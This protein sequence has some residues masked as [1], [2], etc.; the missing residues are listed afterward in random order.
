MKRM[1][2]R[3]TAMLMSVIMLVSFLLP[4]Y[5]TAMA[6][7]STLDS[8]NGTPEGLVIT[9]PDGTTE[10]VDE[11]WEDEFPYGIFAL[12]KS[13]MMLAEGGDTRVLTVYRLGG[14][15]GKASAIIQYV[16]A[17]TENA[18]GTYSYNSA[19]SADDIVIAVEDALPIT[20]Y[21]AWGKPA[22]PEASGTKLLAKDG[23][24]GEG[25]E[26]I[27]LYTEIE[28]E[29]YVWYVL[30]DGE[31]IEIDYA[32]GKELP[33][34]E[35]DLES[36]D[37][38]CVYTVDGVSYSTDSYNGVAYEK[39]EAEVLPEMPQ[40]INL[41]PEKTYT[42]L[43]L[44]EGEDMYSGWL[45]E[46][47]FADGEYQ[48]DILIT[49][50]DD[51]AAELQ[52]FATF[53]IVDNVGG[54]VHESINTTIISI[55][56][57]DE[58]IA[59][60]AVIG[61][62]IDEASFDK[63]N[64]TAVLTVERTDNGTKAVS[65]DWSV[66]D[67]SAKS[68][69]DFVSSSGTLYF[70]GE[71]NT[72]T[73]TLEL[74]N[75]KVESYEDKEFT[76]KLSNILGD[77]GAAFSSDTCT[78]KLFNSDSSDVLNLPSTVY[79]IDAEDVSGSVKEDSSANMHSGVIGGTQ[80]EGNGLNPL[81]AGNNYATIDW[82]G[83]NG[84]ELSPLLYSGYGKITFP[85]GSWQRTVSHT[86]T[87]SGK[88][89]HTTTKSIPKLGSMY[90]KLVSNTTGIAALASAWKLTWRGM[91]YTYSYFQYKLGDK[92]VRKN[93]EHRAWKSGTTYNV[94][95]S[96]NIYL[97]ESWGYSNNDGSITVG[98]ARHDAHDCEN[99]ISATAKVELRRR[100]YDNNFYLDIYT[101]NDDDMK[102]VAKYSKDNYENIEP[103]IAYV[104][105]AGGASGG[106]MYVGSSFKLTLGNT[107]L[108]C[109]AAYIVNGNNV[110]ARG[111]VSGNTATFSN[112]NT[113]PSGD[114]Y[115][116]VI[117]DRKQNINI[118]VDTSSE[119]DANGNLVANA[120]ETAAALFKSRVADGKVTVG[121][122]VRANSDRYL[123][124]NT[125]AE[126]S[127]DIK[128][129]SLS[130]GILKLVS[131]NNVANIQYINFNLP[132]EDVVMFAGKA[133][134]GNDK[135]YLETKHLTPND[136]QFLYYHE[137]FLTAQRPMRVTLDSTAVYFD[138]NGN[139]QI[140]GYF[141]VESGV[142]VLTEV[143]G[144]KDEFVAYLD[145][146]DYEETTFAPKT[147]GSGK[148]Y[149][150]FMRPYYTANPVCLVIP[151]GHSE[152][153]RM[154]VMPNFITDVTNSSSYEA[155]TDE[156]KQYRTIISG[157]TK[158]ESDGALHYS[159]DNHY[160]YT[161]AASAY[162]YIDIPLGGDTNP[163]YAVESKDLKASAPQNGR[164]T[165]D[166]VSYMAKD[167]LA[168]Y[169]SA[170]GNENLGNAVYKWEPKYYGN[171]LYDFDAPSPINIAHSIAGDNI[172]ITS[173]LETVYQKVDGTWTTT[174]PTGNGAGYAKNSLG[175]YVVSVRAK[176]DGIKALNE[177]LGSFAD[178][179]T[180][181]LIVNEQSRT[182]GE[183]LDGL[184]TL[185]DSDD[186]TAETVTRG[187]VGL[188]PNSDY[189]KQNSS[190]RAGGSQSN[191]GQSEY[192][193]F[194]MDA[195]PNLFSFSSSALGMLSVETDG[196]EISLGIGIPVYSKDTGGQTGSAVNTFTDIKETG[197][198]IGQF[199]RD[200]K[201][202][203]GNAWSNLTSDDF[204]NKGNM[205]KSF[206]F[207]LSVAIGIKLKYN[208]LD[209][210][211]K[212]AEAAISF[213]AGVEFR[214]QYRFT[215][216]P[217]LYV[218]AQFGFEVTVQTG[219]GQD[220]E[221]V[222]GKVILN[223]KTI[224]LNSGADGE[225]K[226]YYAFITD[227]K[228][229]NV[230]FDGKMLMEFYDVDDK[231]NNGI[232]DEGIDEVIAPAEGYN[233]GFISSDGKSNTEVVIKRQDGFELDKDVLVILTAINDGEKSKK[234]NINRIALIKDVKQD[235]YW[236]GVSI[237]LSGSIELGAGIGIDLAKAE[238][239]VKANI[240]F[241]FTLGAYDNEANKQMPATIDEFG[242]S[243]GI[244]FRIVLLF[245]D[246]EQD[247]INYFLKYSDDKWTHGWSALG[248]KYGG[249]S[250]LSVGEDEK[251]NVYI[252]TPSQVR[253][254][255]YGNNVNGTEGDLTEQ[256]YTSN[257][258]DF[259]VSGYGASVNAF[260]LIGDVETGYDYKIV[261]VGE[262]NY[263]VYTGTNKN[264]GAA[265]DNTELWLS[266]LEE[267]D[268]VY[269]FVNPIAGKGTAP[270]K[271]ITV[272]GD[273]TGDLDFYAWADEDGKSINVVWVSYDEKTTVSAK[274][275]GNAYG[276]M[277]AE[278]YKTIAKP[279]SPAGN[280]PIRSDYHISS[281][282]YSALSELLKDGYTLDAVSG[283]YYA[284][285]Y[286][287]LSAA[288]QAFTNADAA[289]KSAVEAVESY[290]KWYSYFRGNDPEMQLVDASQN[291]VVKFASFDTADTASEGFTSAVE[292]S[293]DAITTY[294]FLPRSAGEATVYA[295]S[296][297]YSDE[298]LEERLEEYEDY[299]DNI[300]KFDSSEVDDSYENSSKNYLEASKQYRLNYQRGMLSVYGGNSRLTV[301]IPGKT[302]TNNVMYVSRHQ[303]D[304]NG[305]AAEQT[306]EILT[307]I[308]IAE[309]DGTYYLAY[310]TSQD[311][312]EA[313]LSDSSSISRFY[314]RTFKVN[315][316][317]AVE[318]GTPYLIR[319]V[320]N[321]EENNA[322]DGAYIGGS[323]VGYKDAYIANVSFL[324]GKIGDKLTGEEEIFSP[325]GVVED[326][327]F[328][329]FEM[330]G[331]TY[332][333]QEDS[334]KSIVGSANK[335]VISPFFTI[336]QTHGDAVAEDTNESHS[337]GKSE[338]VVGAD[339]DGNVAAV[340]TSSVAGTSNNAI[341]ISY[342][343]AENGAWSSGVMLAMNYMDVYER[344]LA[345]GWD[346]L[347][348]EAAYLN[349]ELGGGMTSLVFTNIQMALGRA[350]TPASLNTLS[351]NGE[352][353]VSN[354]VSAYGYGEA[355]TSLGI[356]LPDNEEEM[357]TFAEEFDAAK[358][359]EISEKLELMGI[360]TGLRT[361]DSPE[362]L[363]LTQGA[364]TELY[365]YTGANGSKIIAAKNKK[366]EDTA[367]HSNL[368][369]Y[370]I[371]YGK[372][373]QQVGNASIRFGYNE[374]SVGSKLYAK[375]SFK[376]V[377]D[378]AIRGSVD[379]PITVSLHV[380]DADGAG[381]TLTS[382]QITQSIGAGQTVELSTDKALCA[383]LT[384][385]LGNND[386]FY[387]T[388][389]EHDYAD[390]PYVY[391]SVT[392]ENCFYTFNVENKTELAVEGLEAKI[393]G[394]T[395]EGKSIVETSFDVTNRGS[396]LAEEVY[397]QL[398]Y[399]SRYNEDGSAVYSPLD[400]TDSDIY[401]SHQKLITDD[402]SLLG[403]NDL[404]NGI[405]YLGSDEKFYTE[406]YYITKE[407]YNAILS[408][409][410][411]T[412]SVPGWEKGTYNGNSYWFD[413]LYFNSAYAAYTA[414]QEA[415]SGW[416]KG[417]E[418]YYYNNSYKNFDA[419]KNAA[420]A[421][422]MAEYILNSEQYSA[423]LDSEKES[424]KKATDNQSY[425]IPIGYE[426]YA[427]AYAAYESACE[428]TTQDIM[429]DY[430]R[431]VEGEI[432]VAPDKF[433]GKLT[434]SLDIKVE[435]F[436]KTSGLS[437]V[438]A[439]LHIS[440]HADEYHSI[441]N[442]DTRSLE[443]T[444]FISGAPKIVIARGS[445]YTL[446]VEIR[447]T[448]GKLP[449]ISVVEV[450]DGADEISTLYYTADKD[451]DNVA[452]TATGAV[453][454][455]GRTL[456]EGVI[457]IIDSATNTT[458]P[459]AYVVAE[460]GDGVNIYNDDAQFK[461]YNSDNSPYD[462][463]ELDQSWSFKDMASWTE[464]PAVPY[465][466]NISIGEKGAYFTFNTKASEFSFDLIGSAI[467]K[468]NRFP[469]EYVINHNGETAPPTSHTIDFGNDTHITHT[470]TVIITS[471]I[472]YFDTVH[473]TYDGEYTPNDDTEAPGLYFS[474]S[475]PTAESVKRGETITLTVYAVDE[476]GLQGMQF[477][478]EP[479][480]AENIVKS[481]IGLW[482][483]TF[484][485]SENCEFTVS[486]SDTNG[487][488]TSRTIE[489]DW[490][491]DNATTGYGKSPELNVELKKVVDNNPEPL[492]PSTVLLATDIP[493]G[494]HILAD[495]SASGANI[496]YSEFNSDM[497]SFSDRTGE[498]AN[499][500]TSNGYYMVTAKST[501]SYETWSAYIFAL[502][503]VEAVPEI[504]VSQ[505]E[506]TAPNGVILSYVA[507]KDEE[508]TAKL[509]SVTV[510]G[511]ELIDNLTAQSASHSGSVTANYGGM[512]TF[513][514]YDS[515]N[516]MGLTNADIKVPIDISNEATFKYV[517]AWG[518]PNS[519][520]AS[521]GEL[522]INFNKI[523]GGDYANTAAVSSFDDYY[524]SYE[525]VVLEKSAIANNPMPGELTDGDVSWISELEFTAAGHNDVVS[526]KELK[527]TANSSSE[528]VVIIR[529]RQNP[530]EYSTM[531]V[532]EFTLTDNAIDIDNVY[533]L[534]ASSESASDGKIYLLANKGATG[535]YEFAI[536]ENE[537]DTANS[538][539]E[540]TVYLPVS[541]SDFMQSSVVWKLA[542]IGSNGD[543]VT[544]EG[545]GAGKYTIAVRALYANDNDVEQI[546]LLAANVISAENELANATSELEVSIENMISS[547][548]SAQSAWAAAA[549]I[550]EDAKSVY[551]DLLNK[552]SGGDMSIT[553][554]QIDNAYEE[555]QNA[556]SA[557]AITASAYESSLIGIDGETLAN[558]MSLRAAW[559]AASPDDK[560][561]ARAV[562]EAAVADYCKAYKELEFAN[563][564]SLANTE[565]QN[566]QNGY[567]S[568]AESV[569]TMSAN[570]YTNNAKY[571]DGMIITQ[572]VS[573][574]V[575]TPA[576]VTLTSTA[577]RVG[578]PTGTV[579]ATA[580]GGTAY[581][582]GDKVHY[583]FAFM[584]IDSAYDAFDT[585]GNMADIANIG[586]KWYFADN[587]SEAA[588]SYLFEG[589]DA[590]LYQVFVRVVYDPDVT[591]ATDVNSLLVKVGADNT[592]AAAKSVYDA[593][594]AA[595]T[596]DA[597][598]SAANTTHELYAAYLADGDTEKLNAYLAAINNSN[599]V[600]TARN[601]WEAAAEED[602]ANAYNT[603][604]DEL[605]D[606][607]EQAANDRLAAAENEYVVLVDM[608][609]KE[610]DKAYEQNPANY[611]TTAGGI[612]S[613]GVKVAPT[614]SGDDEPEEE[615]SAIKDVE[616]TTDK[617]IY[618]LDE[619]TTL[620]KDDAEEIYSDNGKKD[621]ILEIDDRTVIIEEGQLENANEVIDIVN[622]FT[623]NDGNVVE[624]ITESGEKNIVP[625]CL[626]EDGK[627]LY[628]YVGP[629]SYNVIFNN[630]SFDD[631]EN[632]WAK[633]NIIFTANREL[634]KGV[635]ENLF[636]P[637]GTVTRAMM[638]T[639]V[640][641]LAGEPEVIGE[642]PFEDVAKGTWYY[643]AILWGYQNNVIMGISKDKFDPDG[644]ITR[645][646]MVALI[647]RYLDAKG[648]AGDERSDIAKYLDSESV[649]EYAKE[650]FS[651][652][653]A[654]GIVCGTDRNTLK[655]KANATRA[656]IAAI[657]ERII[658]YILK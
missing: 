56:D 77:D 202:K 138:K 251:I 183:I 400:L 86:I 408:R 220:R 189:L 459:I 374:F 375:V 407:E 412:T 626:V 533:A 201:N 285:A 648:Y 454:I 365:E 153:E 229:F 301:N 417:D 242:L 89:N 179:D 79:D 501:D 198:K 642:M 517:N 415:V 554:D 103:T 494:G 3:I 35:G 95:Y 101:A 48:K 502:D 155:L 186:K 83:N 314:L 282:E 273:G 34:S 435:V 113:N 601:A 611:N 61:F 561:D 193:E 617:V 169:Y 511:M 90:D 110:I 610:V 269:G 380:Y 468:S 292:L 640:Y 398:S 588:N 487:N 73:I 550:T 137:D 370:A 194:E 176:A 383:P 197:D 630:V 317:G 559:R 266:K 29:E 376:N 132:K 49:A 646:Q 553:Q 460:E 656:Q 331:C 211:Y 196:Y 240:D 426:S 239:F 582:G 546:K 570:V 121:Y 597:L 81:S 320:V 276:G 259:Q 635:T 637:E 651:F 377:G 336:E 483:Y 262:T 629:E 602:K 258:N 498:V 246:Y 394:I 395:N 633:E 141:S 609:E 171:L 82:G 379:Q 389:S 569:K 457:H 479:I 447:T 523:S 652:S 54:D 598:I 486:A 405:I 30:S 215:P 302:L 299:L 576:S 272:D 60:S 226:N 507:T 157:K 134:A 16:P 170:T 441:N 616:T 129:S 423:L 166:G 274:P 497:A 33:L 428:D 585:N 131:E 390:N 123:F 579:T 227:K 565:L 658:R 345:N 529:D 571:Y 105:G 293:D 270:Q 244:G 245:F 104:D 152:D 518:Q 140:D 316:S 250:E 349:T 397:V 62:A 287:S 76:V 446:P 356:T 543:A 247:L 59:E 540:N 214:L 117:L 442:S 254:E 209:N 371:S 257:T 527:V 145:D 593:A 253:A 21:Q 300:L 542:D 116:K 167:G 192:D 151:T 23:I 404:A 378:A 18:D 328:L 452:S 471:D 456:G 634:F 339:G 233:T 647:F 20:E 291:T 451:N 445:E 373:G 453:T 222:E 311:F 235:L 284:V 219:L 195:N 556:V 632:H 309:I 288:Q 584:H 645:E 32:E 327:T 382:W 237:S 500:L 592:L 418:N 119:V 643:D 147:D 495:A 555:W 566:A 525:F 620:T 87:V 165:V 638:A 572:N 88:G 436:S 213:S 439:G 338:V 530:T 187:T 541:E 391:N 363:I 304:G 190:D 587:L 175:L 657:T 263:V 333:I 615:D 409:Y 264:A 411:S 99:T 621:V 432:R 622:S 115:I 568:L 144:V 443:Q 96:S 289:Y 521:Y 27:I 139:G 549:V 504:R 305:I 580:N 520:K 353:T 218:Y 403:V 80:T 25:E 567:A 260:K 47:C 631:I 124:D 156:Q 591:D 416:S 199:I 271:Y 424:W 618:I 208:A 14:T 310:V 578:K 75:D 603:Y 275:S 67:G 455:I 26:C 295:Q 230:T 159:A 489:A 444:S 51:S 524:G 127:V 330:N 2:K 205:V 143:N 324:N 480:A 606:C 142:F 212:F 343:D 107:H 158:I 563:R 243:A 422:R 481:D 277:T 474:R 162:S 535:N 653:D 126:K 402:M 526:A 399:A 136:L 419:A 66:E 332:V 231:N 346:K 223:N 368:S 369:V 547:I 122:S 514:V 605:Y 473:L 644:Y 118:S 613:V 55:E 410:Y 181:A 203:S 357:E 639:V 359:Y 256:A 294:Y 342:W 52:E 341:Y 628:V 5:A 476:S 348:T 499:K 24:D 488:T 178:N 623:A 279:S 72:A 655:P 120:H 180:F 84:D 241:A 191:D 366:D 387:I 490:F 184:G 414:G 319:S 503:C 475:F 130:N 207:S 313:D 267:T 604:F 40:D 496:T 612:I 298:E 50:K 204:A 467:V 177:Y 440:D 43:V 31:W 463:D 388:L 534:L 69:V 340:Y 172:P 464:S 641:R 8:V 470:I 493:N 393:T 221:A 491:G 234:V 307:N 188:Y 344:S 484:N 562:Y 58:E 329:L 450:E 421:A 160:K 37:F 636:D 539:D 575:G 146:I 225:T 46:V 510:N 515:K 551:D 280:A 625:I 650:A 437:K 528:F 590:G 581:D 360:N 200:V 413:K 564:I 248:G 98:L 161:A 531:A 466:G 92:T 148:V 297:L 458:Y 509:K 392:D 372:G 13:E 654:A 283:N 355:L 608:L 427:E 619:E 448:T 595:V 516:V 163:S 429:G 560:S 9:N 38:R 114:C 1:L 74:I 85:S 57:N 477:N 65:V 522:I 513:K 296:V 255:V 352:A 364:L 649:A 438:D 557:E 19:I 396:K 249:E 594:K 45:F 164:F 232:F 433:C 354:D 461:F 326:E 347:E 78:V 536:I 508:S 135:I 182:T 431:T 149:Q 128:N 538:T 367:A 381:Q 217:V 334:L 286:E 325:F 185:A 384:A 537:V 315:G 469:G 154:Q 224:T 335:G 15:L 261:T 216:V 36:Y 6:N 238:I 206:E 425:Y 28:A 22:E 12:G 100:L 512:Y 39:P 323:L 7:T 210:T 607:L 174:E 627:I 337:S 278:N 482:S 303:E 68:G 358:M 430:Y 583:Q 401:V 44:A 53:T 589:M 125:I 614:P 228:A 133:Y 465:L 4:T 306:H 434:G 577:S 97:S 91:E 63:A 599:D 573:I 173:D 478:G 70:Y 71:Q 290:E 168:Y 544:F 93:V 506:I 64:G 11:S 268:D 362:L 600:I 322:K 109:V 472:A 42:P 558:I 596:E 462:E 321:F 519:G 552:L 386:Y 532:H 361:S 150:Y 624:Y 111:T 492:T 17:V 351:A 281:I 112:F 10:V 312:F 252:K 41:T 108:K 420:E 318:W 548:D 406:D 385:S 102:G 106:K 485:V 236:E 449:I 265:V 586:L 545:L 350:A 505:K 94:T 574:L 308:D